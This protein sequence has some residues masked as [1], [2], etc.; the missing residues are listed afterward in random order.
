ML[1]ANRK[2]ALPLTPDSKHGM[3]AMAD[4]PQKKGGQA[5]ARSLSST[6]RREIAR[7]A[8]RVR[9][10][11]IS[12]PSNLPR[13]THQGVLRIGDVEVEVYR[14]KDGRRLIAK[15]AMAKALMLKSEG[16]NAFLRT[17]TR[18]GVRSAID[19][20]LWER[21]ENPIFFKL[22]GGDSEA[23][24]ATAD[25]Y[26]AATLIDVCDALIRARNEGLLAAS[27]EFLAR[28]AE[29]IMR[30][31]AKTG[32]AALVDEAVGYSEDK[33]RDEYRQLFQAFIRAE[34]RQWERE[35]PDRFPDMIYRLYG[36]KR[37]DPSSS[38]HPRFFAKF[39][40]K[41]VYHP[42]ANSNGMILEAL[43]EKNPVVYASGT[44][45][46]KLHQ[47]LS[48]EVGLPAFRQHIWQVIGIGSGA[49]N[50]QQ[51]D[52]AFYRAFPEAVPRG[53]QYRI[54]GLDDDEA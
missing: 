38:K 28:Q 5:R 26:E 3:A 35:V 1:A 39:M 41:Y 18:K 9:W 53:H 42:L 47:F 16:G 30:S 20:E 27:Q 21:I 33:R 54:D 15:K 19:A 40:R 32:I 43:D 22:L 13:A 11:R 49:A 7:E 45:R 14:L 50:R 24:G 34:F 25:G 46:Y 51:F 12:D 29:I 23:I 17:V 52:R 36:L 8:A 2:Q 48:E 44:R 37:A 31:A 6:R 10:E 4:S